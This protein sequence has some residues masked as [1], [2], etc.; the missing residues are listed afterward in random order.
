MELIPLFYYV[1]VFERILHFSCPKTKTR[2]I[3]LDKFSYDNYRSNFLDD[4]LTTDKVLKTIESIPFNYS[5]VDTKNRCVH[6]GLK[7]DVVL[8]EDSRLAV[9][10]KSFF[11]TQRKI[12]QTNEK[13]D[14]KKQNIYSTLRIIPTF[15]TKRNKYAHF[16][17]IRADD[18]YFEIVFYSLAK[19]LLH[20]SPSPFEHPE[21]SPDYK[22]CFENYFLPQFEVEPDFNS[23]KLVQRNINVH[24][25]T[26]HEIITIKEGKRVSKCNFRSK[27]YSL[28]TLRGN[29]YAVSNVDGLDFHDISNE[30][31]KL[32]Y[33]LKLE[34]YFEDVIIFHNFAIVVFDYHTNILLDIKMRK[35]KNIRGH[36]GITHLDSKGEFLLTW[37]KESKRVERYLLKDL[38][39]F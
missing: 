5:K 8:N 13:I 17:T 37:N 28:P 38:L 3:S 19:P 33:K 32:W 22:V 15:W 11:G 39:V 6:H 9:I 27:A 2:L 35:K 16:L 7:F 23:L 12:F 14:V 34:R 24:D 4:W 36:F 20:I 29:W 10:A 26:E 25:F 30:K 1:P 18:K 21:L 31:G